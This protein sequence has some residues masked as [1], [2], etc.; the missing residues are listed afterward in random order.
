MQAKGQRKKAWSSK[1]RNAGL[2]RS[3]SR[4]PPSTSNLHMH[5]E[6]HQTLK[7]RELRINTEI[8]WNF[9]IYANYA[10]LTMQSVSSANG[11]EPFHCPLRALHAKIKKVAV[12]RGRAASNVEFRCLVWRHRVH[13]LSTFRHRVCTVD[14]PQIAD[15]LMKLPVIMVVQGAFRSWLRNLSQNA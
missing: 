13:S 4:R 7:L 15:H 14:A 6:N 11:P 10:L 5:H 2:R 9:W 1:P 8:T 12:Q 3:V